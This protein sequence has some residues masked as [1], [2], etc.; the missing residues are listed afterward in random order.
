MTKGTVLLLLFLL[1]LAAF[2]LI[3]L[4]FGRTSKKRNGAEGSSA[5]DILAKLDSPGRL[6]GFLRKTHAAL[7]VTVLGEV[8]E[9]VSPEKWDEIGGLVKKLELERELL[10]LL[11]HESEE[12][13]AAAA[14]VL[15]EI[16]LPGAV[17]PL[18]G[19]LGDKNEGVQLSAAAA[20]KKIRDPKAVKPLIEI[21]KHPQRWV[22]ARAAEV[23]IAFGEEASDALLMEWPSLGDKAG[24]A[25]EILGEIGDQ[26]A[27]PKLIELYSTSK[28]S[29]QRAAAVEALGKIRGEDMDIISFCERVLSDKSWEVRIRAVEILRSSRG[30]RAAALLEK[31]IKDEEWKVRAAAESALREIAAAQEE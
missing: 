7:W 14:D 6:E 16:N 23:L 27:V 3:Y 2:I 30:R 10:S 19:C 12:V 20:L 26:R 17:E 4:G 15:G 5:E 29:R 9:K 22:P 13:R 24:L 11:S 25:A 18:V 28:D 31:F 1:L 8:L 21:L